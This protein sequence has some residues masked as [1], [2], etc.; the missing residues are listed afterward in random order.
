MALDAT[1]RETNFRDSVRKYLYDNLKAV[2]G[3]PLY[4]RQDFTTLDVRTNK[5]VEKW[6]VARFGDLELGHMSEGLVEIRPCTR[7]DESRFKLIQMTD[8]IVGYLTPGSGDGTQRITFYQSAEAAVD[9]VE[10][11]GIM[12]HNIHVSADMTAEDGTNFKVITAVLR[13]ASKV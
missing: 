10:I 3:Y 9:W 11:G 12:I 6:I 13:F 2:E 1:A 5:T 4:F 7:N 8:K